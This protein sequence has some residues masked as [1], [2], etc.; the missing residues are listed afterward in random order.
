MTSDTANE[1]SRPVQYLPTQQAY[2]LWSSVYDSDGNFLQALDTLCLKKLLPKFLSHLPSPASTIYID[3]G[4]G[5]GRGTTEL[6]RCLSTSVKPKKTV[7]GL[8]N[9]AAM[10]DIAK[11]KLDSEIAGAPNVTLSLSVF[12]ILDPP[13]VSPIPPASA[14]I[15]TLVLEHIPIQTF[16]ATASKLLSP[17]GIF[18]VTNMHAEMGRV[19]QAGFVDPQT[20]HKVRP[21]SFAYEIGDV[22]KEAEQHGLE[23]IED[24]TDEKTIDEEMVEKLGERS[25][26]W[27]GGIKV[28]FSVGFRKGE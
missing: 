5:T 1:P 3:F 10:L 16:F 6:I 15:S 7:Y 9:S 8:D 13:E 2:S 25:K 26:K 14:M 23:V 28:W 21:E 20:G 19:S 11:P 4:C 24:L 22:V 18:L 27:V 12:D 17:G